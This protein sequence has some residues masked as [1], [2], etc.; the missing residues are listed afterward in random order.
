MNLITG[1]NNTGKSSVLEA[2]RILA[3]DASPS[4]LSNVLNYREENLGDFEDNPRL[5]DT[6][7][8]SL[9]VSLFSGFP[10]ISTKTQPITI[11]SKGLARQLNLTLRIGWLS[12]ERGDEG[13]LRLLGKQPG[14]PIPELQEEGFPVLVA[15]LSF[16]IAYH[17]VGSTAPFIL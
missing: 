7:N 3:S 5:D 16:E 11:E 6:E 12:R 15:D 13:R 1:R 2:L 8:P 9:L 14:L 10:E 17:N 4:V